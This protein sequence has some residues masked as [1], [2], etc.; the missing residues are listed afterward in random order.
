MS[1]LAIKRGRRGTQPT[2]EWAIEVEMKL[3]RLGL[4]K[5]DFA[6]LANL[7]HSQVVSVLTG[8]RI[9]PDTQAK[10]LSKVAEL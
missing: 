1:Q 6:K 9:S 7:N 8:S 3:R 4:T 2:P 5:S 10:I